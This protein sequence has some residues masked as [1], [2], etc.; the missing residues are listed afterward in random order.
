MLK[1]RSKMGHGAG[2]RIDA[3]EFDTVS[4]KNNNRRVP[5]L[6]GSTGRLLNAAALA[7][8]RRRN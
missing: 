4:P 3:R 5:A 8:S 2:Q 7:M 1:T 6:G